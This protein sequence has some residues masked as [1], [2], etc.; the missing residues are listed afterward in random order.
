M[1]RSFGFVRDDIVMDEEKQLRAATSWQH[2]PRHTESCLGDE[3][4]SYLKRRSRTFEKNTAVV[5]VWELVIPATLQRFCRLDRRVGNAL[6]IEAQPGP[7]L[8][9][10]QMLST[11]LL[12]RIQAQAPRCGIQ[13][14]RVVPMKTP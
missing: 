11:E 6:Y 14:I 8:H 5:T 1:S 13:K 7:Y 2:R 10:V 3:I 9:Q 4:S 12:N